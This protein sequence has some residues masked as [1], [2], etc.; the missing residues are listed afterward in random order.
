ML[1]LILLAVLTT[2]EILLRWLVPYNIGYYTGLKLSN[3]LVRYPFGDM[4]FN[5]AGYPDREWS[6]EDSRE[7]VAFVGDSV[8]MGFGAGYGYRFSDLVREA[9]PDK[10]FMNFGGAGEDGIATRKIIDAI[11]AL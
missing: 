8:T 5:S 10:Y 9:R 2:A 3:R 11:L 4:P 1:V 7:R 6:T